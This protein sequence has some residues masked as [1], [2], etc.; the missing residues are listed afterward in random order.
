M[1]YLFRTSLVLGVVRLR[2][3]PLLLARISACSLACAGLLGCGSAR[4][5]G[6]F[7]IASQKY[8]IAFDAARS[9]LKNH[10]FEFDRVD[11]AAGVITTSDKPSAGLAAP[12][13][14]D[15]TT[16]SQELEDF[17]NHQH[18]RVRVTFAKS[19]GAA[20]AAETTADESAWRGIVQVT[21][22]RMQAPGLRIPSKSASLTSVTS[23]P[24]LAEKGIWYPYQ[25]PVARDVELEKRLADEIE[26]EMAKKSAR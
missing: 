13:D 12:W 2:A 6:E 26:R 21:S 20:P 1:Q 14:L 18:R 19:E 5:S 11:A 7:N 22:Y 10:R 8:H 9:V 3:V 16:F 23:D 24:Q 25:T 4:P 15:Q 17:A